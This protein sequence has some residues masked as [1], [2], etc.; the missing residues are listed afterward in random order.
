MR[1]TLIVFL[2]CGLIGCQI[3]SRA[4]TIADYRPKSLP[5]EKKAP[6]SEVF[7]LWRWYPVAP[8]V[9]GAATQPTAGAGRQHPV[10]VEQV[11]AS[12]GSPVGFRHRDNQL[13]AIAGTTTKPLEEAHYTWKTL[14]YSSQ[15][16]QNSARYADDVGPVAVEVLAA[17]GLFLIEILLPDPD[18]DNDDYNAAD[19][20]TSGGKRHHSNSSAHGTPRP[21]RPKTPASQP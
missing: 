1:T 12:R 5:I 4:L 20:G 10:E 3:D 8:L 21:E 15:R 19:A 9:T 7:V 6:D 14:P 2:I 18:N 16:S 11:Y 13:I 17:S